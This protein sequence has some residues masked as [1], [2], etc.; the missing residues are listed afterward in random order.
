MI[1]SIGLT[2][3]TFTNPA[4]V[5]LSTLSISTSG[6]LKKDQLTGRV[7]VAGG[8]NAYIE[9]TFLVKFIF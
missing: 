7:Q 8:K 4:L 9:K 5:H 2:K 6:S 1:P 3:K